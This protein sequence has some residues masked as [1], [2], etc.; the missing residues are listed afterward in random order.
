MS[1]IEIQDKEE[2][3]SYAFLFTVKSMS[4]YRVSLANIFPYKSRIYNPGIICTVYLGEYL[5]FKIAFHNG[6]ELGVIKNS[7]DWTIK[8][9]WSQLKIGC[10]YSYVSVIWEYILG[11]CS[12][13]KKYICFFL[14]HWYVASS[15][16]FL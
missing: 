10:M 4:K 5:N 15:V 16:Q 2:V 6:L 13:S 7:C 3:F 8:N 1:Q 11:A 9:W 14:S 12:C